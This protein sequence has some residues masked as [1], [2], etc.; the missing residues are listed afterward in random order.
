MQRWIREPLLHFLALGALIFLVYGIVANEDVD[1]NEIFISRGQQENLV[2]T[3][4]RTWQRL[5]TPQEYQG[6]LRDYIR[7]EIA[8][9]QSRELGLDENDIVIRRRLRQKMEMLAEDV[10]GLVPPT[11]EELQDYLDGNPAEFA[12]EPRFG[13]Y[14]LYFSVDRRGDEARDDALQA[15]GALGEGLPDADALAIGDPLPL[16]ALLED[17][18]LTDVGRLFG[19]VF[20]E[21]VA[22]VEP[23][24]WQGPV[25]S[26]FGWHLVYVFEVEPGRQPALE[27]VRPAVE[28]EVK[29]LRRKASI[30]G[31]YDRLAENYRIEI[32]PLLPD[33]QGAAA[34]Q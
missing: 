13:L 28:L 24:R 15:L 7:Q 34:S 1:E 32:E 8:Y 17:S 2:N 14:Q 18:S 29:N 4:S 21:S 10:A 12:I 23:G 11:D 25:E 26:G 6:L 27:E 16:P 3:F 31:L 5:P 9:R 22:G 19:E 20:A 33:D 30:D